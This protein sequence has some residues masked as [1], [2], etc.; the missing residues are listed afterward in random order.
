MSVEQYARDMVGEPSRAERAARF[1]AL[2]DPHRLAIVDELAVADRAPS[3]VGR[4]LGIESNLLAHHLRVLERVGLVERLVSDGDRRRR[5]LRLTPDGALVVVG[6]ESIPA[7]NVVFV[8]TGNSARSQ[9]AAALWNRVH[10]VPATSA[11]THPGPQVHPKAVLA[12]AAA[13]LDLAAAVPRSLAELAVEPDLV[14]TVCDLA[15]EELTPEPWP[16]LH[17]SLPDPARDGRR[18]AF[19]ATVQRLRQRIDRVAPAVQP[20]RRRPRHPSTPRHSGGTVHA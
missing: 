14:I 4:R 20:V 2:G 16:E 12:G 5:Y 19:D 7:G 13:G 15:H 8:C 1:A 6:I 18:A 17:W 3:E 10:P 9:L 11:G